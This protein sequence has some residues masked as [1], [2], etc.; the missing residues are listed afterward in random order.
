MQ[1]HWV[2]HQL[3][4][5]LGGAWQA[6]PLGASGFC[7]TWE[8]TSDGG[9]LFVKSAA[10][11]RAGMLEAEAD[12]LQALARHGSI[13]VPQVRALACGEGEVL[14][15]LEWLAFASPDAGFG[16]RLGA[17]L[18]ALHAAPCP[19]QAPA[20]GWTRD[21]FVGATPQV[22]ARTHD[23]P[24]FVAESRL[25]AMRDRLPGEPALQAAVD[26]VIAC[27]PD[28]LAEP[29]GVPRLIHGDLW[30]GNWGMLADGTPVV[31]DPAVSCSD[32][33]ADLAMMH[34]F[35]QPPAGF[36]AAYEAGGGRWPRGERMQVHQLYH[37]L[38][39]AVLFGGGY[40]QQALHLAR[41]LA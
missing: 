23:W 41:A 30:Q 8:A 29:P 37:L 4:A 12:G 17:A 9:R 20:F 18:A 2:S 1:A 39:H 26:R 21:N 11:Y 16:A 31:F 40:A 33:E 15:A 24:A 35:G 6:R 27:L 7:D 25:G 32:P 13:R 28:R 22:N 5:T 3:T 36:R 14:L 10:G 38:N 19:L 34:L